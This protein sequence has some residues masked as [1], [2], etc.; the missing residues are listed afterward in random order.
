[1]DDYQAIE[2]RQRMRDIRNHAVALFMLCISLF[3]L[4]T[5]MFY[6]ALIP[7]FW[8]TFKVGKEKGREEAHRDLEEATTWMQ[9]VPSRDRHGNGYCFRTQSRLTPPKI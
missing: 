4:Y 8:L 7:M 5:H 6:L 2:R 1:M 9:E 3:A